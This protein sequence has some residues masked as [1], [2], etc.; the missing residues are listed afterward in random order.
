MRA[1]F[2]GL[3]YRLSR[4]LPLLVCS[5]VAAWGQLYTGS[6]TG[7][8][9]DPS[10][11]PVAGAKITLT[12]ADRNTSSTVRQTAQAGIFFDRYLRAPIRSRWKQRASNSSKS[13]TL[14]SR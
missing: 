13:A 5:T 7:T 1:Q 6:F 14:R 8:V 12:D 10:G 3:G 9:L 2:R 4:S 11:A